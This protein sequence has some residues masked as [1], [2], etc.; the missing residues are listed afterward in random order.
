MS[1]EGVLAK[2][3]KDILDR[4]F[5]LVV[6]AY[7]KET[8][9]FLRRERNPFAN[10]VG[11]AIREGIEG[12]FAE[13][14]EAESDRARVSP[15]LD[16]IIRVRAIQDFSPSAAVAFIFL[17]KRIVREALA[18]EMTE[19][20]LST[21]DLLAFESRVDELGLMAFDVYAACREELNQIRLNEVKNRTA[22]LLQRAGM[23]A[24]APGEAENGP[25]SPT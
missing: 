22:R 6:E 9:A 25:E 14:L 19:G 8:S 10:P 13:V 3:R 16:R 18:A 15:F 2:H 4:W 1:L 7:P 17:L 21:G 5:H 11:R 24:G 12:V 23:V 20:A